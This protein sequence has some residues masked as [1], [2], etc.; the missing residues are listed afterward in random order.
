MLSKK[1][2]ILKKKIEAFKSRNINVDREDLIKFLDNVYFKHNKENKKTL[3]KFLLEDNFE[4][5]ISYLMSD[6]IINPK[7]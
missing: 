6:A 4:D 5:I 1:E 2:V 7:F 3:E